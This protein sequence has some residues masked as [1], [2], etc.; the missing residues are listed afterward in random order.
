MESRD[1][2]YF[3]VIA[4]L[5][6][7]GKAAKTL[8][9]S[10]P[11]L[12]HC[13]DRLEGKIGAQL[14]ERAGRR[15]KLTPIG[16]KLLDRAKTLRQSHEDMVRELQDYVYGNKGH[17]TVGCSPSMGAYIVP[18]LIAELMKES[19]A[20]TIDLSIGASGELLDKLRAR[21]LD[22]LF[23]P[24]SYLGEDI[25]AI[26]FLKND[27]VVAVRENHPILDKP[28]TIHDLDAYNWIMTTDSRY[29]TQWLTEALLSCGCPPPRIR[30]TI[31]IVSAM[32]ELIVATDS[33]CFLSR[34]HV[35]HSD[36]RQLRELEI[37][38]LVFRRICSVAYRKH[39]YLSPI[40]SRLVRLAVDKSP[41]P[42]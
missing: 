13:I 40:A 1:L 17:I 16:E 27:M 20:I 35:I 22:L 42:P 14:F 41:S 38:E 34:L 33:L 3:E 26:P 28:Y 9:K 2:Y 24:M 30:T 4:K 25:T 6:H 21:Q 15:I 36:K 12:S 18:P 23:S 8:F 19:C 32:K 7:L 29:S 11:A 10:Q 39:D 31:N 5:G 37:P